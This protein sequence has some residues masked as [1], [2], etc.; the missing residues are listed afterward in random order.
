ML[1]QKS[2]IMDKFM[3]AALDEAKSG[4]EEKGMPIG[5]V[6]VLNGNIIGRGRNQWHQKGSVILHAEM[7]AIE[8]AGKLTPEEYRSSIMY[9]TLSPCQMCS[10]TI[11]YL[12]ISKV[13]IA[14]NQTVMGAEEFLKS[15]GVEL[16]YQES[17]ESKL[18]FEQYKSL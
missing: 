11:V 9:T 5:S 15:H 6:L 18:L 10:G 16:S 2:S 17:S 7:D 13:V 14:D 3:L 1:I 4:M 12:G 8:N